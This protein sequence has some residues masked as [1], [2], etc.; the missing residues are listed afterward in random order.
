MKKSNFSFSHASKTRGTRKRLFAATVLVLLILF[1]DLLSG[2]AIRAM[3]RGAYVRVWSAGSG[4]VSGI[5]ES[6]FFS[7]RRALERENGSLRERLSELETKS[8]SFSVLRQENDSL[9]SLLKVAERAPGITASIVSSVRSS[10]YGTFLIGAG[11]EDGVAPGSL[12][13]AADSAGDGFVLGVV[14]EADARTALVKE[15]FGPGISTEASVRG[16]SVV[17]EGQGGG[18]ARAEA[19]RNLPVV[20]GDPVTAPSLGGYPIG[21]V[22][23]VKTE[24]SS[25]ESDVYIGLPV[26]LAGLS[27]VY[28]VAQ[29]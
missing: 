6:G 10:P 12:V 1:A 29:Y 25:A 9:R 5:F 13:L 23:A 26:S 20:A 16:A 19:P 11:S 24:A 15:L 18:N 4:V 2:G 14:Q 17:V 28:V 3:V 22:G 7:T 8:A 21:V 27:F